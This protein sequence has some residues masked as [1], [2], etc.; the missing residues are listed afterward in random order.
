[1]VTIAPAPK[2]RAV[3]QTRGMPKPVNVDADGKYYALIWRVLSL[4]TV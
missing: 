4:I 2:K 3:T 1:M